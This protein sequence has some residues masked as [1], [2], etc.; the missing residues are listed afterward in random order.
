[1]VPIHN[2]GEIE[3]RLY[4]DLRLIEGRDL[5]TLI[6]DDGGRLHPVRAVAIV[7]QVASALDSA[8]HAG[9]VHRDVKPSNILIAARDFVYLIDFG[10]ARAVTDTAMTNT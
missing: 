4:V 9:L 5:G 1:V 10:I 3:G 7:E 2:Y 8:H 6:A